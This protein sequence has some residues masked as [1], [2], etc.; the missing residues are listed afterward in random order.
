MPLLDDSFGKK[1]NAKYLQ[2]DIIYYD[3]SKCSF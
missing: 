3:S 1:V 2:Y